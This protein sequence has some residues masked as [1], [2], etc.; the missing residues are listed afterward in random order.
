[1]KTVDYDLYCSSPFMECS[2]RE[3]YKFNNALMNNKIL[4]KKSGSKGQ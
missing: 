1:M 2:K 3:P 4:C